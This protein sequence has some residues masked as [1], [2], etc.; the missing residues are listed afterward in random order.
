MDHPRS[1]QALASLAVLTGLVLP[2]T[3]LDLEAPEGVTGPYVPI[4]VWE[5]A[6]LLIAEPAPIATAWGAWHAEP[7]HADPL[8]ELT[9]TD[10]QWCEWYFALSDAGFDLDQTAQDLTR[11]ILVTIARP[12][13]PAPS[14][15]Q[16]RPTIPAFVSVPIS[17]ASVLE[18]LGVISFEPHA[19]LAWAEV[20][21][22][23]TK[24]YRQVTF[25]GEGEKP[26]G[27]LDF[28]GHAPSTETITA[29]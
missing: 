11:P 28:A 9:S 22:E 19:D 14:G 15:A 18:S 8:M 27:T 2:T 26:H 12:H 20:P 13:T 4:S 24:P 25:L 21:Q 5:M 3:G 17:T 16:T 29:E 10:D 6:P 1:L 23:F 7:V